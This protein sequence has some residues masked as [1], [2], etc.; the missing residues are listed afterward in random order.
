MKGKL[1][2]YCLFLKNN[3]GEI[4][5]RNKICRLFTNIEKI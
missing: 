2:I 1:H 3:R 4:E 5:N